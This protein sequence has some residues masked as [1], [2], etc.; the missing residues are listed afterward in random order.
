MNYNRIGETG[1]P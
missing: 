1:V